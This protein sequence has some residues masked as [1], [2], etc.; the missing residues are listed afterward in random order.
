MRKPVDSFSSVLERARWL[1]A[2]TRCAIMDGTF[3]L[4]RLMA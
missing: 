3:E 4:I 1:L 2:L